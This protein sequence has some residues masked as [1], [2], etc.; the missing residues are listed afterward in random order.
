MAL[1]NQSK[2][3]GSIGFE[4]DELE[5]GMKRWAATM[6]MTVGDRVATFLKMEDRVQI[7]VWDREERVFIGGIQEDIVAFE[8]AINEFWKVGKERMSTTFGF[9]SEFKNRGIVFKLKQM[10]SD[11]NNVGAYLQNDSK[12]VIVTKLNDLIRLSGVGD[13]SYTD[14]T[15]SHIKKTG[16]CVLVEILLRHLDGIKKD[17]KTWFYGL[18][19]G[20]WNRVSKVVL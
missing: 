9:M 10:T 19:K 6:I 12:T 5:T 2:R 8:R 17:G 7:Y 3:E 16:M 18:E 4:S 20:E 15:A 1:L 13:I 14:E 11:K